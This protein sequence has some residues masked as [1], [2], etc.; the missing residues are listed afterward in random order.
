V[1]AT[2]ARSRLRALA[3]AV[4][5]V[6]G[7][8]AAVVG[9][10]LLPAGGGWAPERRGPDGVREVGL[11]AY[12]WG[13]APRVVQVRPGERV[14]FIVLSEDI[15]HGF[16]IN[17]LGLN[18]ALR[19]GKASRSPAVEVNLP[20]GRYAIHCSAFCGLGHAS[21]KAT[22]VVGDP[23]PAP[24]RRAPWMASLAS[25]AL[26]V[27]VAGFLWGRKGTGA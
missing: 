2:P 20:E 23:P 22:L 13:F 12:T 25:L 17:E 26:A 19:S 7:L 4:A 10:V 5:L 24:G 15:E 8:G 18:L 1:R 6:G 14:R 16:A 11:R 27:G 21:M 9:S 3:A